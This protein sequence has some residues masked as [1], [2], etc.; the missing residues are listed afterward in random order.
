MFWSC[1]GLAAPNQ[2]IMHILFNVCLRHAE[3]KWQL[4][5]LFSALQS[6]FPLVP[7]QYQIK[8]RLRWFGADLV[9]L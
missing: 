3:L 9:N 1:S 4:H 6:H 5:V 8:V 7:E 2:I